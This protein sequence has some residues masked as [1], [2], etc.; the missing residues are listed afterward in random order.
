MSINLSAY[1]NISN[2]LLLVLGGLKQVE[3]IEKES[4]VKYINEKNNLH[5]DEK[6]LSISWSESRMKQLLLYTNLCDSTGLITY[7]SE[8][9]LAEKVGCSVRTIKLNNQI[10]KEANIITWNR[11]YSDFISVEFTKYLVDILD[12]RLDKENNKTYSSGYTTLSS[13]D[14][15]KLLALDDVNA[16]RLSLRILRN[17]E[18]D[19]NLGKKEEFHLSYKEIKAFL[20]NYIG[21]KSAIKKVFSK[22]GDL[23]N[24]QL[25]DS[26]E[27][28]SSF[29]SKNKATLP[30]VEKAKDTFLYSVKVDKTSKQLK[31]QDEVNLQQ[32]E[33]S[34]TSSIKDYIQYRAGTTRLD[35]MERSALITSFGLNVVKEAFKKIA[36]AFECC[37]V[38]YHK[39][40]EKYEESL[41]NLELIKEFN[42]N[43][44]VCLRKLS[45]NL[46]LSKNLAI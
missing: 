33:G 8:E 10:F 42:Q 18:V 5:I 15:E 30:L 22:V 6:F 17:V 2:K 28:M 34:F 46:I 12:L 20:P 27:K 11:I 40:D 24:V 14:F 32:F 43:N 3:K 38:R 7:L 1:S 16:L 37:A 41:V 21:Y 13:K 44:S 26:K 35:A 29:F 25:I 36:S 9:S 23:F 19:I 4:E 39:C 31:E 45:E